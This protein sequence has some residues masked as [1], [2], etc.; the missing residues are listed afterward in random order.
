MSTIEASILMPVIILITIFILIKSM[1]LYDS[2]AMQNCEYE[3]LTNQLSAQY[4]DYSNSCKNYSDDDIASAA[5]SISLL[6]EKPVYTSV[7]SGNLLYLI[8]KRKS[9]SMVYVDNINYCEIL[10]KESALLSQC[11]NK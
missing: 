6:S 10:R 2:A 9:A 11:K 7:L 8:N 1:E 3:L 4:T 5:Y